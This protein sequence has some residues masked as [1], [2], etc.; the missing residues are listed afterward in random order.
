M[1]S[2]SRSRLASFLENPQKALWTLAIPIMFG[3]GIHTLYNIVDMLFIGRLGGD[4]IAGVAFNML[5]FFLML[6]LTMGLGSGVTASIARLIGEK[7]KRGADN[8]AEHAIAMAASISGVFTLL[9]IYF[10]KDI[11][12]MLGAEGD[13]L[14]LGWDYLS[15]IVL[16]LYGFFRFFRSI[17]AGEGDMKFP[18]MVAGLGTILNIIL[19]PIFIFD[20]EDYGNFGLGMGVK[21]A[22]LATVVSQL[23]VFLIFIYML[24]VK[25]HAYI[26]FNLKDFTPSRSILWDIIKVG[27]PASLS[28][29]IMAVGQ[30]VFN[31][32]LIHYSSQTVA[33]YKLQVD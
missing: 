2:N 4:A 12:S 19:D 9:G 6:G 17:L 3:M 26:T 31:K 23:S 14:T 13:I 27:L 10:G 5:I 8:S 28:M 32:I 21:G 30:G 20:L 1:E 22:A 29:I 15:M 33:A 11:L 24:F 25:E 16:A 18:M 7:D